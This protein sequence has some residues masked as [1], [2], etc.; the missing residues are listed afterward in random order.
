MNARF[1]AH[2]NGSP[3][4]I[5]L[6]PSQRLSWAVQYRTEEG[7]HAEGQE[8]SHPEPGLVE[9]VC[10]S[11]GTDCD[12][13]VSTNASFYCLTN[14]L[15]AGDTPG[16]YGSTRLEAPAWRGVVWP[17]WQSSGYRQRDYTAE[18]AGY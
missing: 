14:Q 15:Q 4:K 6:K 1:W 12:G 9:N 11:D 13:R 10:W 16:V 2:V 3:V 17:A 7:W 5:T 8:W 18:D